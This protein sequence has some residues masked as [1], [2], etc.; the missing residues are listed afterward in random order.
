V[1]P[2]EQTQLARASAV[3][4]AA[5]EAYL[6]GRFYANK[7]TEDDLR[8]AISYFEEATRIDPD[9][10]LGYA[11]LADAHRQRSIWGDV[12]FSESAP[13]IRAAVLKALQLDG[14]LA[15]GHTALGA[16]KFEYDWD[17]TGAEKDLQRALELN[18]NYAD[19]HLEYSFLLSAVGRQSKAIEHIQRARELDPLSPAT[20][21]D[22]G[23]IYYRARQYEKAIEY[24]RKTIELDPTNVPVYGRLSNV[25]AVQGRYREAQAALEQ[26]SRITGARRN[27]EAFGYLYAV[28]G[29]TEKALDAILEL[30]Q[31]GAQ[32]YYPIALIYLGLGDK[33]QAMAWLEKA[34]QERVFMIFLKT[35]PRLDPLRDDPRF[36]ALLRR[37]NFPEN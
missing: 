26:G 9:F 32:A 25:Y 3:S 15:E 28:T 35:E 13:L 24:Y 4:P 8:K 21:S 2:A 29:Q 12:P 16:I 36:Q 27:L 1:T 14:S 5:H 34:Y 30:K 37:M 23:R 17:W 19:A 6:L 11:G 31:H 33:D 20:L 10:A 22:V 18:P 7:R